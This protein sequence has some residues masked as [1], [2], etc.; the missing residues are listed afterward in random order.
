MQRIAISLFP[1]M[2]LA[3]CQSVPLAE[4][5]KT[6]I[7]RATQSWVV[8][9]N[10]CATDRIMAL[11]DREAVLWPT[12]SREIANSPDKIRQYFERVCSSAM[13]P[14][15]A[16]NEQNIRM[17]GD[18]AINSGTYTFT[19]MRDG[20]PVAIPAR[21]SFTYR[22]QGGQWLIVDHHSSGMPAAPR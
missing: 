15:G 1:V 12:T 6:E 5:S 16:L 8:A 20:K 7:D 9:L 2:L 14:Q 22:R 18:M 3:G 19:I 17:Y 4:S 21:F 13:R 11:Y 10:A